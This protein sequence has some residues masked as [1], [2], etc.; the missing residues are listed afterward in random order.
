MRILHIS[1]LHYGT[2]IPKTSTDGKH[3]SSHVFTDNLGDPDPQHLAKILTK[4]DSKA[5]G[6][7]DALV[8][9]GDLGWSGDSSDYTYALRFLTE[10]RTA[11]PKTLIVIAAGN[12]DVSWELSKSGQNP[13]RPFIEFLQNVYGSDFTKFFLYRNVSDS[14][15][16]HLLAAIQEEKDA[17]FV[18]VNTAADLHHEPERSG[19]CIAESS[20]R[21]G[22]S[23]NVSSTPQ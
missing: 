15:D 2:F 12:H 17:I 4:Q 20:H 22:R 18:S 8:I 16:R 23:V 7:P 10:L 21:I 9:S 1:D 6:T 5:I 3:Q 14:E 13:Q 11:W 19:L